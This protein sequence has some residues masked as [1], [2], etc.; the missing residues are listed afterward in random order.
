MH[1]LP[2]LI[3]LSIVTISYNNITSYDLYKKYQN[4]MYYLG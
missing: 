1:V 4:I 2:R 3:M